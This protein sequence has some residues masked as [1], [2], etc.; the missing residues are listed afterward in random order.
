MNVFERF[1]VPTVVNAAGP[2]TRLGGARLSEP[3]VEAM[4]SAAGR[5]VRIE[6]LQARAGEVIAGHTG[7]EAGY[8]TSGAA[9][10]MTLAAAACVAGLDVGTMDR[11]PDTDGLPNQ[12]VMQRPHRTA[13]EHAIRAAGVQIVEVGYTGHPGA[14]CT[15]PWQIEQAITSKTVAVAHAVMRAPGTVP[16]ADVAEIAHRR[17]VPVIV[18]AA[19]ALPPLDNL[20]RFIA[21]GADLVA[22]S[23]GKAIGGPQASGILCGRADLIRSVALQHQDM[24]VRPDT[25]TLRHEL[26]DTG[27]LPGPPHH[28]LGRSMKVGKEE[29]VGLLVALEAFVA[30]DHAADRRRWES[31]LESLTSALA[32]VSGLRCRPL[33]PDAAPRPYPYLLIDVDPRAFGHTAV[34]VVNL[35]QQGVPPICVAEGFV[36]EG[37]IAIIPTQ[38]A[39]GDE[40]L[41]A[42]RLARLAD[43]SA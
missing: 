39:D 31:M 35:L 12:V 6:D 3:V 9:A 32:P 24:D 41:I 7:A 27:V 42:E 22:F 23:G 33:S 17:G 34:E 4:R 38:L 1:G 10:G 13:Y 25:W 28:G 2:L 20:R 15:H 26:L 29:I 19:A 36:D 8:V 30:R 14:G 18:D 40:Q 11:L 21:E 5:H 43:A 16:L 37:A